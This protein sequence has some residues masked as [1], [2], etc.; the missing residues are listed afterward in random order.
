MV[1]FQIHTQKYEQLCVHLIKHIKYCVYNVY[2]DFI[3]GIPDFRLNDT[4]KGI[5]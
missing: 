2:S 3:I 4:I 5:C 1:I